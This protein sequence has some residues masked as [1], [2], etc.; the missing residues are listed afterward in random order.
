MKFKKILLWSCLLIFAATLFA[1]ISCAKK[2]G[3]GKGESG[4]DYYT[5]S[6]HPS[7]RSQDPKAKCPICGMDLIPV[8]KRKSPT[9]STGKNDA[10]S[11]GMSEKEHSKMHEKKSAAG[12][13]EMMDMPGMK[14]M[15][16]KNKDKMK[17]DD[18]PSEFIIPVARQQMIGVTYA[19]VEKKSLQQILRVVGT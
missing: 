9:D 13:K 2:D 5:C 17:A 4:V 6:M 16:T 10:K 18:E 12:S 1:F 15:D 14:G 3:A 8:M 11:M 19:T 7:V